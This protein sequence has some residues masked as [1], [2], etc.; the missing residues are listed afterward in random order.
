MADDDSMGGSETR[1]PKLKIFHKLFAAILL[2]ALGVLLVSVLV[3]QWWMNRGFLEYLNTT[4][5]EEA[6][7]IRERLVVEYRMAGSW[8]R[9]REDRRLWEMIVENKTLDT[10]IAEAKARRAANRRGGPREDEPRQGRPGDEG[11]RDGQRPR[12]RDRNRDDR[13]GFDPNDPNDGYRPGYSDGYQND[14]GL[15]GRDSAGGPDEGDP[16]PPPP[17]N[18][19]RPEPRGERPRER[20]NG[21]G[22]RPPERNR[23]DNLGPRG[24]RRAG[25]EQRAYGDPGPT[26]NNLPNRQGPGGFQ[27]EPDNHDSPDD[28]RRRRGRRPPPPP[29][30]EAPP[31]RHDGPPPRHALYDIDGSRVVGGG[32]KRE[33]ADMFPIEFG[34]VVVGELWVKKLAEVTDDADLA[35]LRRQAATTGWLILCLI[36]LLALIAWLLA[37]HLLRP[38]RDLS[39]A[40]QDL[41]KGRYE[42]DLPERGGDELA[43]LARSFNHLGHV[44]ANTE[45][46]RRRWVADISHELRTPLAVLRGEIEAI[47]DGI[48]KPT[49]ENLASLHQEIN[50]L[51]RLVNDLY[52]LALSDAGALQYH[53]E[54]VSL[55]DLVHETTSLFEVVLAEKNLQLRCE[56][57]K[58]PAL[59]QADARRIQQLI[60]NL[61]ENSRRYTDPDGTVLISLTRDDHS[62]FLRVED[63]APSV[64]EEGCRLLFERFHREEGSRSR[65]FGGAGLG[66]S[67]CRNIAEA[68]RGKIEAAPSSLGGVAV[69]LT[70]PRGKG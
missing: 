68:H 9:L 58:E 28:G 24:D 38:V 4:S 21:P 16:P 30:R 62:W 70:L 37:R 14:G 13:D 57:P 53:M 65:E 11:F 59:V 54:D 56:L 29:P 5:V 35:Y 63:S 32:F 51:N 44:L 20:R 12:P 46:A 40:A 43:A 25:E 7:A 36:P 41:G 61:L 8:D 3:L 64:S 67:I 48:R 19:E 55:R 47:L 17:P 1:M 60:T 2:T 33:D 49:E 18:D 34:G 50:G 52:E 42:L 10:I 45:Q 23:Q 15:N 39:R 22:G 66:L 31:P 6:K 69:T 26:D 27:P